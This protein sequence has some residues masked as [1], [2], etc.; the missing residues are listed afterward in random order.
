MHFKL[1]SLALVALLGVQA[2]AQLTAADIS[3]DIEMVHEVYDESIDYLTSHGPDSVD[4]YS[5]L[6][7]FFDSLTSGYLK[8]ADDLRRNVQLSDSDRASLRKE[9]YKL[10]G[11]LHDFYA[12]FYKE[13]TT[14]YWVKYLDIRETSENIEMLIK[15]V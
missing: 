1:V 10:D 9:L 4:Y 11:D 15:T 14:K 3:K 12:S 13:I 7:G 2:Y 8:I 5:H 6:D